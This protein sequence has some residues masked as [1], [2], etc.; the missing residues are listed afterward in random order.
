MKE[1]DELNE[2]MDS[3]EEIMD[4][5][6]K[7]NTTMEKQ[8]AK[9]TEIKIPDYSEAID[10]LTCE[11]RESRENNQSDEYA[12]LLKAMK[13]TLSAMEDAFDKTAENR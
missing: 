9:L 2:R 8:I 5:L 11:V 13:K 7:S 1:I 3:T 12:P 6:V 10:K 4:N